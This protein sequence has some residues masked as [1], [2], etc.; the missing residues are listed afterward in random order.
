[1]KTEVENGI[2]TIDIKKKISSNTT[3][4]MLVEYSEEMD[5]L[6]MS[7]ASTVKGESLL[8]SKNMKLDVS[9]AGDITL[10][11]E[12]ENLKVDMSG[13]STLVL[14]G[15]AS[16]QSVDASGAGS[17]EAL[18]L[19]CDITS[20]ESSGACSI[21]V[22]ARKELKGDCSG[23][24]VIKY[25]GSPERLSVEISGAGSIKKVD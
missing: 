21:Y 7:G 16:K 1:I 22:V 19:E 14:S 15:K 20:I 2:L 17:Y 5:F 13:A 6:D 4:K 3:I 23:A 9:G 12:C 11:V 18:D 25:K 24:G 10:S 8:Q